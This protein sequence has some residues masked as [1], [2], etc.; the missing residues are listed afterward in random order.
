MRT[1]LLVLLLAACAVP[2][3]L[4]GLNRSG[5]ARAGGHTF[6]VN[7]NLERAQ[8]TRTNPAWLPDLGQV[9]LAAV[10]ATEI[11]TGCAVNPARTLGDVTLVNLQLDCGRR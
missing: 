10:E 5:T 8:A 2:H 9:I 4:D 7:W 6:R 3:P 11:V 1:L